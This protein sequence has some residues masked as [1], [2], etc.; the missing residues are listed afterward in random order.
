MAFTQTSE[1]PASAS[2]PIRDDAANQ[3][4]HA[5]REAE[6][7]AKEVESALH[8]HRRTS[9]DSEKVLLSIRQA[10]DT[11]LARNLELTSK[12]AAADDRVAE[13]EY[14]RE[15]ADQARDAALQLVQDLSQT[16]DEFRE[17]VLALSA[18]NSALQQAKRDAEHEAEIARKTPTD[19]PSASELDEARRKLAGIEAAGALSRTQLEKNVAALTEQLAATARARDIAVGA[20][21]SAQRQIENLSA[22]RKALRAQ[23]DADRATFEARLAQVESRLPLAESAPSESA[24]L[25]P[26]CDYAAPVEDAGTALAAMRACIET[27]AA[28]PGNQEFLGELDEHFHGYAARAGGGGSAAI[29]R[30]SSACGE[31]TRW[32]RKTPRKAPAML[33]SLRDA[34]TLLGALSGGGAIADPAGARIYSVDDDID[35]CECVAMSL[36]KM[37]LQT[38]YAVKPEIALN[39]LA[40]GPYDLII[41]DVDLPGMDGFELSGRIREFAHHRAT[42]IIFLSGLMSAKARVD[43]LPG[44][45]H[46]FIAKPYNLNELAVIAVG[47]ILKARLDSASAGVTVPNV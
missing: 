42:P 29:A 12:L 27:L 43:S 6:R 11:V 3:L 22:E 41:L 44:G 47:M 36:E 23:I 15:A 7:L 10:R 9:E 24:S 19:A 4:D 20:V 46:A 16:S 8:G 30:Y 18:E 35:N 37:A 40:A 31:L 33:D 5:Q 39:D 25:P 28:D 34:V 21:S 45:G 2:S 1:P 32:M 26:S 38:R 14:E 13:L 17:K